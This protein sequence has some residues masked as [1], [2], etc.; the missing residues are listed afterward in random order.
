MSWSKSL[1]A[2][3]GDTMVGPSSYLEPTLFS[4][5]PCGWDWCWSSLS[6]SVVQTFVRSV[7]ELLV[8]GFIMGFLPVMEGGLVGLVVVAFDRYFFGVQ[9]RV[10]PQRLQLEI[11]VVYQL[12]LVQVVILEELG[13]R[14]SNEPRWSVE[15]GSWVH[16]IEFFC[17][18]HHVLGLGPDEGHLSFISVHPSLRGVESHMLA[19]PITLL[20][21]RRVDNQRHVVSHFIALSIR[22][23]VLQD[24]VPT[25]ALFVQTF[26]IFQ[27]HHQWLNLFVIAFRAVWVG[28]RIF[29]LARLFHRV[30][31]HN[32]LT[33]LGKE[34]ILRFNLLKCLELITARHQ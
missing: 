1:S 32:L 5:S 25:L 7:L 11:R 29:V 2:S 30:L 6:R 31:L 26:F 21:D 15:I 8:S 20:L 34:W 27:R 28:G 4:T 10:V 9:T 22:W 18:L 33:K 12:R 16:S 24:C 14:F 23:V 19:A 17:L 3:I 13:H